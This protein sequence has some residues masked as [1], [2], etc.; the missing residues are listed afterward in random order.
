MFTH[1]QTQIS[2]NPYSKRLASKIKA[3]VLI[4][5]KMSKQLLI[6]YYIWLFF[7]EDVWKKNKNEDQSLHLKGI[8][9]TFWIKKSWVENVILESA[10][11]YAQRFQSCILCSKG[12]GTPQVS[13]HT[14]IGLNDLDTE[15]SY[16]WI[17]GSTSAY[18]PPWVSGQPDNNGDEDCAEIRTSGLND[19]TCAINRQSLCRM[20]EMRFYFIYFNSSR[21][22]YRYSLDIYY[23]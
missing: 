10:L 7:T 2:R 1:C 4:L 8:N 22:I 13:Q 19:L 9:L 6:K 23:Q 11:N 12:S 17:D 15:G 5:N 16:T 20:S 14:Y 18:R 3:C 21:I